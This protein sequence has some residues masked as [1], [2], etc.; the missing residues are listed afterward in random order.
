MGLAAAVEV[1]GAV[2]AGA[3]LLFSNGEAGRGSAAGFTSASAVQPFLRLR[4]VWFGLRLRF[5]FMD[6]HRRLFRR[7]RRYLWLRLRFGFNN[8][9]HDRLRRRR[10]LKIGRRH[11]CDLYRLRRRRLFNNLMYRGIKQPATTA[12]WIATDSSVGH[13]K[14]RGKSRVI[15]L[16]VVSVENDA[17]ILNANSNHIQ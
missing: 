6:H 14:R 15:A 17:P 12:P 13:G 1:L 4:R 7:F 10:R 11:H 5:R 9:L 3:V 2:R 8:G 16:I